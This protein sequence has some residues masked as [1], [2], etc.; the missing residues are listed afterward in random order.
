MGGE[1]IIKELQ[2]EAHPERVAAIQ[3][4][5]KTGKG[6]YGE[7]DKFIGMYVPDIRKIAK[8]YSEVSFADV[9]QLLHSEIH[10]VRLCGL[11]ILVE[12]FNVNPD[13]VFEFYM[14][15][16]KAVNNWDLVDLTADKIVGKYLFDKDKDVLYKLVKGD[17]WERRIS[18]VSTFYFIKKN[19][20]VDTLKLAELLLTDEHDLMHKAV[21]WMLREVG[22]RDE[23]VLLRFLDKHFKVMPRTMLRYAIERFSKGKREYY[24]QR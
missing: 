1:L 21:G 7:G 13:G 24:M 19:E 10:E 11:L 3:R 8:K 15:N 17:L 23:D 9:K 20:F 12:K 2:G 16:L 14:D 6:Q 22:K 18:I 4:F 5:F